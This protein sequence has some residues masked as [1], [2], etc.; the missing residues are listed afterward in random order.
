MSSWNPHV[1][2]PIQIIEPSF[3]CCSHCEEF[4][5][6]SSHDCLDG[7]SD[8]INGKQAYVDVSF[9]CI[10][11]K[12]LIEYGLCV[13]VYSDDAFDP[14][15]AFQALI[16]RQWRRSIQTYDGPLTVFADHRSI[17]DPK[18]F[19]YAQDVTLLSLSIR[20]RR[21]V[22]G[23]PSNGHTRGPILSTFLKLLD[24]TIF[25][26]SVKV[27]VGG[28]PRLT[29]GTCCWVPRI[30]GTRLTVLVKQSK[31]NFDRNHF[32]NKEHRALCQYLF[33]A[34][35]IS[36]GEG[37]NA[38]F[39]VAASHFLITLIVKITIG[40]VFEANFNCNYNDIG[41][42]PYLINNPTMEQK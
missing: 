3:S 6:H 30:E 11:H 19:G 36:L 1:L 17:G 22:E 29:C 13:A 40:G 10:H 38:P 39:P 20:G 5:A 35:G 8:G 23:F 31:S 16:R 15:I 41:L 33:S 18:R 2:F 21:D 32:G 25:G 7:Q 9:E 12:E 14:L 4:V 27:T 37:A 42:V 34:A 28:V 26:T 24:G